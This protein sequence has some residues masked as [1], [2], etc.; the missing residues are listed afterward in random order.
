MV[1]G[2]S[3]QVGIYLSSR[4]MPLDIDTKK[5]KSVQVFRFAPG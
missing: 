2:Q 4:Y 5:M 1:S 3:S